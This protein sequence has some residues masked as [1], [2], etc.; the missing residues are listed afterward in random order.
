MRRAARA[1]ADRSRSFQ[2]VQRLDG[3]QGGD[4]CLVESSEP[5]AASRAPS[6]RS[7]ARYGGEEFVVLLYD[8]RREQVEE[9][10][11]QLHSAL[12]RARDSSSGLP[13]RSAG[14][15]QH[16]RRAREPT[17][18]R[19]REGLC[20]SPTK[21]CTRRRIAAAIAPSSWIANTKRCAPGR[22]AR[23]KCATTSRRNRRRRP[24]IGLLV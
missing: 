14:D 4:V 6:A 16:R 22:S 23:L 21:R 11:I 7:A 17:Q 12:K 15:V 13:G 19:S 2:G 18:P 8:A 5:V 9:V 20:S 3:H 1:A 10:C 24:S